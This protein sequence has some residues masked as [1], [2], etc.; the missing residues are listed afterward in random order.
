[1]R[2]PPFADNNHCP[3]EGYICT[4]V[5][6]WFTCEVACLLFTRTQLLH[7]ILESGVKDHDVVPVITLIGVQRQVFCKDAISI[8]ESNF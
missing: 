7:V 4:V 5:L 1:M 8:A 2:Q 6:P 3:W